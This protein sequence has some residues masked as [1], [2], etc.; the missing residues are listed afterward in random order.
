MAAQTVSTVRAAA[1]RRRCLSLAKT[2]SIGLRSGEYL[3]RKK[4]LAPAARM[5]R[6]MG[7][8]TVAAEIVDDDDVAWLEGGDEDLLDI[9]QEALAVD[10]SVE[11]PW[12]IDAVMAESGDEGQRLP[13]AVRDARL[14]PLSRMVPSRGAAP[15]WSWSRSRR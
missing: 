1:L 14:Q 7:L 8:A 4:S 3:G 6:R 10:R 5:A 13:A 11:Q 12:R 15:C 2:C 9:G